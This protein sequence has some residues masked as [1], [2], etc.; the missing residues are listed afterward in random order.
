MARDSVRAAPRFAGQTRMCGGFNANGPN[1]PRL[2]S[3]SDSGNASAQGKRRGRGACGDPQLV[4]NVVEMALDGFWA[5]YQLLGDPTVG[6]SL[7]HEPK[8]LRLAAGEATRRPPG[9][10]ADH[11][12]L[13]GCQ[14]LCQGRLPRHS[15]A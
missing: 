2:L 4:E 7:D 12:G 8:D 3:C 13:A 1:G 10:A 11:G 9:R 6:L 14:S 5:E 15:L